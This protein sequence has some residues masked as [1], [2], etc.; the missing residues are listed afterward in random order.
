[1]SSGSAWSVEF[2]EFWEI[3]AFGRLGPSEKRLPGPALSGHSKEPV[4]LP[5]Q[6]TSRFLP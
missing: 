2:V 3:E 5:V 1:M 6:E 4:E